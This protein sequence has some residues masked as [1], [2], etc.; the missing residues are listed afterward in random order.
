MLPFGRTKLLKLEGPQLCFFWVA[1]GPIGACSVPGAHQM[2]ALPEQG[3]YRSLVLAR[4]YCSP[5]QVASVEPTRTC[6]Q[7]R[8]LRADAHLCARQASAPAHMHVL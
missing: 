2:H 7:L 4:L 1:K 5:E 8:V 6:K 3:R